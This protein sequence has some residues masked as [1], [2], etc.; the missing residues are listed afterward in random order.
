MEDLHY[1]DNVKVIDGFYK[2]QQGSVIEGYQ[3]IGFDKDRFANRYGYKVQLGV[4]LAQV[5]IDSCY[6][7]K[8]SENKEV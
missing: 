1:L 5:F 6:L 8:I 2:G 4:S 3:Y 7:E